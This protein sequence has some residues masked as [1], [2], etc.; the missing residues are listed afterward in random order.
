[1]T[2]KRTREHVLEEESKRALKKLLPPEWI[3]RDIVPDYGLDMEVTIVE[4]ENITNKVLMLQIKATEN[5]DKKQET[6]PLQIETK[7][8]TYYESYPLPVIILYYVKPDDVFYSIFAQRY[9]EEILSVDSPNWRKQKTATVRFVRNSMLRN[10]NDLESI[11]T[12]GYLYVVQSKLN[13]EPNGATYWLDGIPKSDDQQLKALMLE[14]LSNAQAENYSTAVDKF[15][16]ILRLCTVSPT[17]KIAILINLGN[18]Y[19]S[20]GKYEIALKNYSAVLDLT[21]KVSERSA[22]EGR[23]SALGNLGLILRLKGNLDDALKYLEDALK[24]HKEI[25]Y[26][27]GEALT[28]GNIG[29]I[30]LNKGQHDNALKYYQEAVKIFRDVGYRQGEANQLTNIGV[31]LRQKGDF[32]NAIIHHKEALK[33]HRAIRFREGE[34]SDL[35]NIGI[36]LRYRGDLDAA[37]EYHQE[38]L[39][40]ETDIRNNRGVASQ[41]GDMGLV[42]AAKGEWDIALKCH[43]DALKIDKEIGYRQGEANQ[44]GNMGLVLK[45]KGDLDGA[46]MC[47]NQAVRISQEIGYKQ[48]EA[49]Q[50]GNVGLIHLAKGDLDNA[51]R[52]LQDSLKIDKEIGY[53]LGELNQLGSIGNVYGAKGEL[54]S[55]LKYHQE[56]LSISRDMGDKQGEASTLANIGLAY[57]AKG[58]LGNALM[59]LDDALRILDRYNL[60]YGRDIILDAI[61]SIKRR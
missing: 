38:A 58:E 36:C 33:I 6:V 30:L 56:A 20:L 31:I 13:T 41:L 45:K 46:L 10:V 29:N 61:A 34:A 25:G 27:Q 9:I 59:Y 15:E 22:L 7:H 51:L 39:R 14:A 21:Q 53:K 1:L 55:A 24:I 4:G 16:T 50:L 5:V 54:E 19:R 26:R 40:I 60:T 23:A 48:G 42:F 3:V 2:M 17:H 49:D 57:S 11:A 44:L 12:D 52:C 28:L 43:E 35:G 8:L 18:A 47:H 37:L 32:D